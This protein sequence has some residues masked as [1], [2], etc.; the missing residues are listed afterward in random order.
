VLLPARALPLL[1]GLTVVDLDA[2]ATGP[3]SLGEAVVTQPLDPGGL[4]P[5][6][7]CAEFGAR[8]L[9]VSSVRGPQT[10]AP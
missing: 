3:G 9:Q 4:L 5:A 1:A 2:L 10:R 8:A 7:G 6:I